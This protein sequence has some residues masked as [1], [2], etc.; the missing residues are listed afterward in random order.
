MVPG[1]RS[2]SG[3][4]KRLQQLL[5]FDRR[6]K[7]RLRSPEGPLAGVDEVGRGP[8][9]GPVV[10]S[11][12]IL[13]ATSFTV[14][15]DDS[16]RLTPLARERAFHV[17]RS[18]ATI[19]LGFIHPEEIDH[20]GIYAAT[21]LA[22]TRAIEGLT[23]TPVMVLVDGLAVPPGLA[24]PAIPIV[25]GDAKSLSIACASIVAKVIRDHWMNKV[26]LLFPDYGFHR[27]K[28]YGTKQHL[29][30]LRQIGPTPLHRFS[31]HPIRQ[32]SLSVS[33][34]E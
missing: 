14:T 33:Q 1:S 6:L 34:D 25:G 28:G 22:M 2:V 21:H 32:R 19:G 10:A 3:R 15:V 18:C 13:H 29:S 8:L 27:H 7:R 4:Y 20:L 9:A 17:I 24:V 5:Q 12:V 26:H 23:L 16:K 11:A 30:I 31:F